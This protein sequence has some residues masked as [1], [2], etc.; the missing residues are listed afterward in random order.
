MKTSLNIT[1]NVG[2]KLISIVF[3]IVCMITNATAKNR[4]I[5]S[6]VNEQKLILNDTGVTGAYPV[7]YTNLMSPEGNNLAL[8]DGVATAFDNDFS[9]A[10]DV[11]DASKLWNFGE[12]IA[13][14]RN[15]TALAIEF[16]PV[17]AAGDT[18]F[19][20]LYL[21]QQPYTLKL[22]TQNFKNMLP[23]QAWL[24]DKYLNTRLQINLYETTLYD[25]TPNS[26]T[27]SY[28]NRFM[29]VL[30]RQIEAT[31]TIVT[32]NISQNGPGTT[33]IAANAVTTKKGA[34]IY[35]NPVTN[36]NAWL[37]FSN[38]PKDMYTIS[39]YNLGGR[40]LINF[41]IQHNGKNTNY[42]LQLN[43]SFSNGIYIVHILSNTIKTPVTLQMEIRK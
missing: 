23:A 36:G 6:G 39:V 1:Q 42:P 38:M 12:N 22:F 10:V 37:S 20:R 17:P 31:S 33:S 29:V 34:S 25:F 13:E 26:D 15:D 43:T 5:F 41:V 9:A 11:N 35:P 32:K 40:R 18:I 30:N 3:A 19:Y 21:R 28:R 14:I 4:N 2:V 27:N 16:R 24:I 7:L 8:M